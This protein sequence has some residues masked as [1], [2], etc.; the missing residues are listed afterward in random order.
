MHHSQQN[1]KL[2]SMNTLVRN[3]RKGL[4]VSIVIPLHNNSQTLTSEILACEK[5][6]KNYCQ[7]YEILICDD[8]S[9]DDSWNILQQKFNNNPH[10]RLYHHSKNQGIAKTIKQLY[11]LAHQNYILLYSVDGDWEVGDIG[12]ILKKEIQTNADIVI[13]VRDKKIYSSYR[14]VVSF[15][16][17]WIPEFIY[18]TKLYDAGSIKLF[19]RSVYQHVPIRSQSQF[20]EAEFLLHAL[21][22]GATIETVPVTYIHSKMNVPTGANIENVLA[23]LW[24]LCKCIVLG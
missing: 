24:D 3:Q 23:S 21:Q 16:Y 4:T 11:T 19:R 2:I 6:V 18:S 14:K 8:A 7:I 17:N 20:F 9:S 10:I 5:I 12:L 22:K 13:G 1:P 15:F